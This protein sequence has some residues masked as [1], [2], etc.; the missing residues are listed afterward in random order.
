MGE[1]LMQWIPFRCGT[2]V[3]LQIAQCFVLHWILRFAQ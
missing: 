1:M 2:D 3:V